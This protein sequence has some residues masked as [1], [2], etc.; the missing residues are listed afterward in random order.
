MVINSNKTRITSNI[1]NTVNF[2]IN[3]VWYYNL[4]TCELFENDVSKT[5]LHKYFSAIIIST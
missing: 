3:Y 4:L 5:Q 1:L 2:L